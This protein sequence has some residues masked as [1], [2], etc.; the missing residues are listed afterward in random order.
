MDPDQTYSPAYLAEDRSRDLIN[1]VLAFAILETFFI[2]L[3]FTARIMN[4]TANGWDF[5]LMIPAYL[6]AFADIVLAARKSFGSF[7][8]KKKK[9]GSAYEFLFVADKRILINLQSWFSMV[10]LGVM[11]QLL[12]QESLFDG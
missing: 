7:E 6:F 11:Q 5:Y 12:T 10:V 2:S 3:F 8:R 1:F 9:T 4:R